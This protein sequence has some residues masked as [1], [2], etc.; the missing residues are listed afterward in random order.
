MRRAAYLLLA[1]VCATG[2]GINLLES[3]TAD[4]PPSLGTRILRFLS[5]FTIESN[6]LVLAVALLLAAG[7][8]RGPGLALAHL[9]ALL[10]ITV[11]GI[12]F[13][14]VLA[15]DQEH[16]GIGSVLLH[17]VSPPLTLLT[18]LAFGPWGARAWA[19]IGPALVWPLV[20]LAWTLVHGAIGGWYPYP[21][22]DVSQHG[23]ATVLR[24]ALGVLVMGLALCVAFIAHDRRRARVASRT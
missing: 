24:N 13:A 19:M 15:P 14:L 6:I 12:V 20:W 4:A 3:I 11:T 22:I 2:L 18:W 10:G 21:F 8:V 17:Y 9:D 16:I 1:V 23:L 5:F 7:A